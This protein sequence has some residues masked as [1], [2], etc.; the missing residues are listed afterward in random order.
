MPWISRDRLKLGHPACKFF[1]FFAFYHY[2][3]ICLMSNITS[4]QKKI[5][6]CS[7]VCGCLALFLS[8][9]TILCVSHHCW[10]LLLWCVCVCMCRCY[11]HCQWNPIEIHT[12]ARNFLKNFNIVRCVESKWH[13]CNCAKQKIST[14]LWNRRAHWIHWIFVYRI[15]IY[16]FWSF[17]YYVYGYSLSPLLVVLQIFRSSSYHTMRVTCIVVSLLQFLQ[18]FLS[19]FHSNRFPCDTCHNIYVYSI[20]NSRLIYCMRVSLHRFSSFVI[21]GWFG[22][23]C[24]LVFVWFAHVNIHLYF[25]LYTLIFYPISHIFVLSLSF[26]KHSVCVCVCHYQWIWATSSRDFLSDSSRLGYSF[27]S[28]CYLAVAV[29]PAA[30]AAVYFH[31]NNNNKNKN[32]KFHIS[33]QF[34][35]TFCLSVRVLYISFCFGLPRIHS[36]YLSLLWHAIFPLA[37]RRINMK[38][39][40]NYGIYQPLHTYTHA[41]VHTHTQTHT[42]IT[43]ARRMKRKRVFVWY[44][45][46]FMARDL[47]YM[48]YA[49]LNSLIC[50]RHV[51]LFFA[52]EVNATNF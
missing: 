34:Q 35:L 7:F 2:A 22:D 24:V 21:R 29:A 23:I 6:F 10:R 8:I 25:I 51:S 5:M 19:N 20:I 37:W 50:T 9:S 11:C 27:S 38:E 45:C 13:M 17:N 26:H 52:I 42:I 28:N 31:S 49:Y 3:L 43:Y 40:K 18:I 33:T 47:L 41:H 1:F 12:I 46:I 14:A 48:Q 39:K 16:I 4:T 36:H 32:K 30:K 44:W 15:C